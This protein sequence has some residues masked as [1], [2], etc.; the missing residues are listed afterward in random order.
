M[1]YEDLKT[2]SKIFEDYIEKNKFEKKNV[3]E[4]SKEKYKNVEADK[5]FKSIIWTTLEFVNNYQGF[6][7]EGAGIASFCLLFIISIENNFNHYQFWYRILLSTIYRT[8]CE[9]Y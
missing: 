3:S 7:S 5:A 4:I 6:Y 1:I 2:L 8:N 9:F